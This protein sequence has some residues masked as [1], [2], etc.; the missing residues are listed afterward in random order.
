MLSRIEITLKV[1]DSRCLRVTE[2]TGLKCIGV[3]DCYTIDKSFSQAELAKVTDA[4]HN[5]VSQSEFTHVKAKFDYT[6]AVEIGFLPGVTDNIGTTAE[7]IISDILKSQFIGDEAVYS[8]VVYLINAPVSKADVARLYN[9]LIQSAVIKTRAELESRQNISIPKVMLSGGGEVSEIDIAAMNDAELEE[10]GNKGIKDAHGFRGPLGLSL[11]Y[12]KAIQAHFKKL[13]RKATDIEIE[14]LAQTWSEHCK[15]TIFAS[16][17]DEVKSGLYKHFIKR[18]TNEIRARKGNKDICVSVFTDNSGAIAFDDNWLITDKVET[19]NSPSALD[20]FGGAITGIVGVNR[21]CLGFGLGAKPIANRYGFCFAS[22][23]APKLFRDKNRT[24]Q[25]LSPSRIAEGVIHG[26][27]VGGNC[28]G[29]PTPSG[30]VYFDARFAG[31]PL[32]FVGTIGIAPRQINGKPVHEKSALAGDKIVMIGGRVGMDGIHGATFSSVELDEGSPATAVQIGDPITQKKFSDAIIRE[33]RQLGLYNAITDNGAGGLSSSIGEMGRDTNGFVVDLE[34]VPLKYSG[35]NPWQIWI[36]ESQ[37]RMTL[38]VSD[39][40]V[41]KLAALFAKRGVEMTVIGEFTNSGRAIAKH[42][43]VVAMDLEMEFLHNGL[44]EKIL[45][46]RKPAYTPQTLNFK[47]AEYSDAQTLLNM[48]ARPNICSK[49]FIATQYD[50]EVQGTSALKPLQG[51]GRVYAEASAIKPLH[52]SPRS[53]VISQGVNPSYGDIDT[54][55][56]AACAIDTAIR[57]AV[58]A[59][60]NPDHLAILDNFCWCSS[61]DAE[62]LYQLKQAAQAC[63]DYAV[64]YGTPF[65]SG[66]DSMFNDFSGYD[67]NGN[68]IKVSAPPTLLVSALGV[69]DN[70]ANLVSL[71]AKNAGDVVY[72]IGETFDEMGGAELL[73]MVDE[74]SPGY[75][76]LL[77]RVHGNVPQVNASKALLIY[78]N[79]HN[80]LNSRLVQSAIAVTIGGIAVALAKK[81]IG[82]NL[83]IVIDATKIPAIKMELATLLYSETQSRIIVTVKPEHKSKFESIMNG[84]CFAEIGVITAD[85]KLHISSI[86]ISL[87][88]LEQAYKN[89]GLQ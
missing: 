1:P 82:G 52:T 24:N 26:V 18:A 46:T 37:E 54:Y 67:E 55:H 5:P 64:A 88:K 79:L 29:I 78:N 12:M 57:N 13:G 34:K 25:M 41:P 48:L 10:I 42:N 23:G 45:K 87:S 60:A 22:S 47:P 43:G 59:G 85:E 63:Y 44:P 21:D 65:I 56:M 35:L 6:N 7:E 58:A 32:V 14:T 53:V 84:V 40:N 80:A 66:K 19:H 30:F 71:D 69:A 33:A 9:P 81:A 2:A 75:N 11:D 28:S 16:E 74:E 20:P 50:H 76:M 62:R 27:N 89:G 31:K 39:V 73:R 83:G 15:H 77:P 68:A 38:A 8:S 72:I 86:E 36:S 3:L 17:I 49:E 61:T 4:L 70:V 51:K